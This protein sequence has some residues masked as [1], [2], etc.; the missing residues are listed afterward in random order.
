MNLLPVLPSYEDEMNARNKMLDKHKDIIFMGAH[1]G[2]LEWSLAELAN[3]F[4]NYENAVVDLGAR[5]GY[6]QYHAATDWE[7][8]RNFCIKYSDRILY[9]TDNVQASDSDPKTFKDEAHKKWLTDWKFLN[10]DSTMQSKDIDLP[11]KG[12]A[13]PRNVID[14]IYRLNAIKLFQKAWR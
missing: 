7:N 1:S 11:F 9:A 5:M 2:S 8:T 6:M 14:K 13:L 4:D 10:T 12:L 3:F